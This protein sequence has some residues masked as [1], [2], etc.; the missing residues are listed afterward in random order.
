VTYSSYHHNTTTQRDSTF[1]NG[2]LSPDTR[3]PVCTGRGY[4]FDRPSAFA[5]DAFDNSNVSY[6]DSFAFIYSLGA[7]AAVDTGVVSIMWL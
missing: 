6:C 7:F 5:A 3:V 4:P 1:I 2:A